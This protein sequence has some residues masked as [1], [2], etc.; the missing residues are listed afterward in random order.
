MQ[1]QIT[2]PPGI[3]ARDHQADHDAEHGRPVDPLPMGGRRCRCRSRC[4]E[5]QSA[6]RPM[7]VVVVDED[8]NHMFEMRLVEN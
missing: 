4:S 2:P 1:K 7:C 3:R 8:R 6:M 5:I